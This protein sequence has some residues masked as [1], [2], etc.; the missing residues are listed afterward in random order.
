MDI[1]AFRTE[2][3]TN[4]LLKVTSLLQTYRHIYPV[5]RYLKHRQ[6][7]LNGYLYPSISDN[8]VKAAVDHQRNEQVAALQS[9]MA[10]TAYL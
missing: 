7:N 10:D 5:Y 9:Q 6:I 2:D 1:F 4:N 3:F 8:Y